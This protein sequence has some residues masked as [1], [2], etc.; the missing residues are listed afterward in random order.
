MSD[1]QFIA[2]S[3]PERFVEVDAAR[4]LLILS[5]FAQEPD[6]TLQG[7]RC[8]P[9][10][11]FIAYFTPEY[12]L[13]KL[14][15]LLRY[16]GYFIYEVIELY[17][18]GK[19][20]SINRDEIIRLIRSILSDNEPELMTLPFR[21]FWRG[22]Y[23]RLDDV[24]NWWYSRQLIYTRLE[25]RGGARPQKY[26]FLSSLAMSEADRLVNEVQ[27]GQWYG[28]RI[29]LIHQFFGNLTPFMIMNLQYAH[30]AYREAQITHIIPDLTFNEIVD[31]FATVFG[32]P[33][34]S[35][36]H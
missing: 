4:L 5:R 20:S 29:G 35:T 8:I 19:I 14:D 22:A 31:H 28:Q 32:E 23:E 10:H 30:P 17:R 26:Y 11:P 25:P 34:D 3:I 9:P 15:F 6:N 12:Y 33:L 1:Q 13:Q 36:V 7:L 27:H 16:P 24:E 21:K 18:L 2:D